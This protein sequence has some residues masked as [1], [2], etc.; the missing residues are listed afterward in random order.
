MAISQRRGNRQRRQR[1][2]DRAVQ[3]RG[4][5]LP[6]APSPAKPS[7]RSPSPPSK[8]ALDRQA[9]AAARSR[10]GAMTKNDRG[11]PARAS[12]DSMA[13]RLACHDPTIHRRMLPRG[14]ARRAPCSRR[15]SRRASR[16]SAR[17]RMPGVADNLA[18]MLEDR[19]ANA[20]ITRRSRERADAPLEDALALLVRE[21][22][23]GRRAAGSG[24]SA[25]RPLAR[26]D[27]GARRRA[28]SS[29]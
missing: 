16:R 24:A 29:A 21:R 2:A 27:R 25:R 26:L 17:A 20:A 5:R 11:D 6:C 18:A 15:S 10:R 14:R 1:S 22:L 8:P 13:L 28:T 7:S 3:A 12:R 23:T 19:Y 4:R 9:C